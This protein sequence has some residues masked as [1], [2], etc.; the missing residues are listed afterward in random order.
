MNRR[1]L[2]LGMVGG[3]Q[4]AFIGAVHRI[5][6]RLD[7][8]YELVAG[9][10][11]SDPERA[12]A[13]A[14]ALRVAP[15]RA[16]ASFAA[17]AEAE[18]GR[19]GG[20]D[21]VSVVTPNH[22]HH[23]ACRAFLDRGIPVICDKP[24]TT[25]LAD[26]R[27]LREAVHASGLPFVLTHNYTGYPMVRQA[28]EM[29]RSGALGTVRVVQVEYPQE[30]LTAA[31][32]ESGQKQAEWRTDPARSGPAGSVGDIGTHA[33]NLA[34]F[35]TGLRLDAVAADLATFV[36]DRRL[37]DNAHMLL[38]FEGGAKG[39]LWCSQVAPGNENG[40]RLRVY[41]ERGGLA[42][43][44]EHPNQISFAEP[45]QPPRILFRGAP[46]LST[47]AQHATRLPSGH[48]EGY[49]EA[50]AQIYADAAELLWAWKEGR[51]PDPAALLVPGVEEGVRG[52]AFITAAVESSR[53]D[54]AWTRLEA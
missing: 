32:E 26:A 13:S 5:A 27:D 42:W 16:Y 52:V 8:H 11:S 28:R 54:A 18:A 37:D 38:R 45:G 36:P 23:A 40:L 48:P 22:L 31:L 25:S 14:A 51:P 53:N 29:V 34:E 3:G 33:H 24:M 39:M 41:G 47:D 1:R 46:G 7:D 9:A 20:A 6:A 2:R 49:L 35:V 12:Q 30:W 19:E 17:M 4:G 43:Q 15:D 21:V 44:Q 10:L 50:F